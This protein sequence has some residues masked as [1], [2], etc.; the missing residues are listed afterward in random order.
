LPAPGFL[1]RMVLGE[2]ADLLLLASCKALPQR[3]EA[4][5]FAF[6]RPDLASELDDLLSR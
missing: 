5:G 6:E 3:L 2:A 1:L 4:L